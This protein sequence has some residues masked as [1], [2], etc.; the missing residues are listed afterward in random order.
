MDTLPK[1]EFP[2]ELITE[3]LTGSITAEGEHQLQ[4]W[5]LSDPCNKEKYFQIQE[6]WKQGTEDYMIYK[7]ANENVGWDKLN[8]HLKNNPSEL[9]ESKPI[10]ITSKSFL[11]RN[12]ISIA[13]SVLILAGIGYWYFQ[14]S[15]KPLYFETAFN[16]HKKIT[17]KDGSVITLQPQTKIEVSGDYNRSDRIIKFGSGE[18]SFEVVHRGDKPFIVELGNTQIKDI[19][20]VFTILK[21]PREIQVSVSSGKVVFIKKM[22]REIKELNSGSSITYNIYSDSFKDFKSVKTPLIDTEQLLNFEDTPLSEAITSVQT[23]F[24]K[25]IIISD[26]KIASKKLTAQLDGMPFNTVMNVICKSLGLEYYLKD[27]V[28]VL[29]AENQ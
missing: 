3:A 26:S 28:Y 13:A 6:L 5:L 11:I 27:S 4:Q 8:V 17:L 21:N 9:K 10:Q 22:T 18:A 14:T 15:N 1:Y 2:W 7:L 23:V 25:K 24:G 29:K 20:T 12:F 19:G 16:E